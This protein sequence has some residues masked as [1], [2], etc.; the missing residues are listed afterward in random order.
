MK[1]LQAYTIRM[2]SVE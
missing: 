1:Q 2:P